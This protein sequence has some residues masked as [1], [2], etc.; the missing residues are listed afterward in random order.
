MIG[1]YYRLL[2]VA[3]TGLAYLQHCLR[4]FKS[5]N[6]G[7]AIAMQTKVVTDTQAAMRLRSSTASHRR[8]EKSRES[9]RRHGII[10]GHCVPSCPDL[11]SWMEYLPCHDVGELKFP[12]CGLIV[13][14]L[15]FILPGNVHDSSDESLSVKKKALGATGNTPVFLRLG[16]SYSG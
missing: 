11:E 8:G 2:L 9:V 5:V 16:G 7:K 14:S 4:H 15:N 13:Q 10:T 12:H 6:F 3:T 1:R